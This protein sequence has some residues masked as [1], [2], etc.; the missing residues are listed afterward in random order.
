[1]ETMSKLASYET[2]TH[3]YVGSIRTIDR[4]ANPWKGKRAKWLSKKR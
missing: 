3:I 2:P 1:M 4:I